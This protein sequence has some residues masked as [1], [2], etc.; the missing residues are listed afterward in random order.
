MLISRNIVHHPF[1]LLNIPVKRI[2][3]TARARPIVRQE[4]EKG[5]ERRSMEKR[6]NHWAA[7]YVSTSDEH[8]SCEKVRRLV[9]IFLAFG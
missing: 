5:T 7:L 9:L 3:P 1:E 4:A 8:C 6:V 2:L